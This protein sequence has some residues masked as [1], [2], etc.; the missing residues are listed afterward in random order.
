[1]TRPV[2]SSSDVGRTIINVTPS[3][4][5]ETGGPLGGPFTGS[6]TYTVTSERPTPVTVEVDAD[7]PWIDLDGGA[8]PLSFVLN[9]VGDSRDVVVGI[10]AAAEALEVGMYNG[11]ATFT[12]VTSGEGDAD[13]DI[14]LEVGRVLYTPTDVPQ[15]IDDYDTIVSQIEVV[16]AYCVGDVDVEIDITHTFIGDLS[17]D[18]TSPSGVTVR[19]HDRSGGSSDDLVT[20]YDEQG[21]TM[22]DGPGSLADFSYAGVTGTWTLTVGD[23][24]SGDQGSLNDWALR[25]VPLGETCPPVANDISLTI[26]EMLPADI[27][28]DAESLQGDP[29]TYIITSLPEHGS[30]ADPNGGDIETVPYALAAGG[31]VVTYDPDNLYVG[32]DGF[33]YMANDGQDSNEAAVD[34]MVGGPQ[35]VHAFNLDFQPMGWSMEGNWAF[36]VPT[37]QAG[38]SGGPD[39]TSGYTGSNVFGYNLNGGYT[40]GMD[41]FYLTTAPARLLRRHRYRTEVLSL[42][43]CRVEL[44][45]SR[46]RRGLQQRHPV[47]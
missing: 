33:D 44:V 22:P 12:N 7:Q 14:L 19:L 20:T 43:R 10:S 29:L 8:G 23:H 34:I 21:G 15:D 47:G 30:L 37:G 40:N 41:R 36:G 42:A 35:P 45:R 3:Y 9:G 5:L 18:L 11:T 16:D 46:W 38:S 17:V 4:G 32:H 39:P 26:P 31:N 25:I 28:L 6:V 13:R 24:A 2:R 1:M 27:T